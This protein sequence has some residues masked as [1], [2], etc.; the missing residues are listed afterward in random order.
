MVE[1]CTACDDSGAGVYD[2]WCATKTSKDNACFL[3]VLH[4]VAN[5]CDH[6]GRSSVGAGR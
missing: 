5:H 6:Y 1:I 2:G 4:F 3:L